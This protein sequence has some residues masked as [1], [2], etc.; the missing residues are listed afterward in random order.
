VPGA[1]VVWTFRDAAYHRTG[2]TLAAPRA[3]PLSAAVVALV[4]AAFSQLD[5][6]GHA[7]SHPRLGVVDH[8]SCHPLEPPSTVEAA[9]EVP[10]HPVD[11][12]RH[13]PYPAADKDRLNHHPSSAKP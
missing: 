13:A 3:A 8:V 9:T 7:A 10:L 4:G 5:L 12:C 1:H 2:F 11:S 6:R